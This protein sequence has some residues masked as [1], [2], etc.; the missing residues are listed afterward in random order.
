MCRPSH[1]VGAKRLKHFWRVC[2]DDGRRAH[3]RIEPD[4][5]STFATR[6]SVHSIDQPNRTDE[7]HFP[8]TGRHALAAGDLQACRAQS[9]N[10]PWYLISFSG[11]LTDR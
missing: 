7:V 10:S 1:V 11:N 8:L 6:T 3:K 9:A 4:A 2:N 5:S